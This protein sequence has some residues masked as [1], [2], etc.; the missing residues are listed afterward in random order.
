[1]KSMLTIKHT[2]IKLRCHGR[3]L[4]GIFQISKALNL[5][6]IKMAGET[7][8]HVVEHIIPASPASLFNCR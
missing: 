8:Q 4:S 1:M 3:L 6:I 7:G 5:G 2:L